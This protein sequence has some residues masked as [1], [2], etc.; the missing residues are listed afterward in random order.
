LTFNLSKENALKKIAVEEHFFT[1]NYLDYMRSRSGITQIPE[2]KGDKGTFEKLENVVPRPGELEECLDVDHGRLKDMDEAGIDMQVLS[3][4]SPG[5]EG[6]DNANDATE[7]ARNTNDE[8]A[9]IVKRHP[10]RYAGFA[11]IACQN[12][13]TAA[14]ELERAV[15]DLGLVGVK[16]N[17]HIQGEYLDDPKFWVIFEKAE[18][19]GVPVYLHPRSPASYWLKPYTKYPILA[20][21]VWGFA[22]ETGLHAM[23]LICSGLFDKY[24]GLQVILGHMGEAFPFW[25]WRVDDHRWE[26]A[27][28]EDPLAPKIKK[29]VSQYMKENFYVTTSGNFYLPALMC[30]YMGLGAERIMFAVDYPMESSH[31]AVKMVES[32]P[33]CDLDKEKIFHLNAEKLLHIK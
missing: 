16:I 7:M 19:L 21:A 20:T 1:Q 12:P 23:R 15:K 29:K 6:M 32:A 2:T 10:S 4:S 13:P 26:R 17:S 31:D 22:A 9:Q 14:R 18:K 33:I 11:T 8:L 27:G 24:P 28:M 30:A 5:V 3:F 25:L